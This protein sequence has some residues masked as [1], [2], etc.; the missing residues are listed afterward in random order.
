MY[1]TLAISCSATA[2]SA[3]QVAPQGD[4]LS[5][6]LPGIVASTEPLLPPS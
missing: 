2:F 4:Q 5:C 3:A 1:E 6:L